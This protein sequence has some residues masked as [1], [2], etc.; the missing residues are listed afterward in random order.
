MASVSC[1]SRLE[2][3]TVRKALRV[4][5]LLGLLL[6]CDDLNEGKRER[7]GEEIARE[8]I[9]HSFENI[10]A[11]KEELGF[12]QSGT[13][14]IYYKI[15]K[16]RPCDR[17]DLVKITKSIHVWEFHFRCPLAKDEDVYVNVWLQPDS[18]TEFVPRANDVSFGRPMYVD[19][20]LEKQV[21]HK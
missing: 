19:K 4:F 13:E 17:Y 3:L 5:V 6:S 15:P 8:G 16:G 1:A 21:K 14:V 10:K 7:F 12:P 9:E 20:E 2:A 11:G 18:F